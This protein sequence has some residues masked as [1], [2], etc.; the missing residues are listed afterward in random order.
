M[1][2]LCVCRICVTSALLD[3]IPSTFNCNLLRVMMG[4]VDWLVFLGRGDIGGV[5]GGDGLMFVL[6]VR[7]E[8]G[9]GGVGL[10][11]GWVAGC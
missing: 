7:E 10:R 6:C 5:G 3:M 9:C 11:W 1:C 8:S 2:M 4:L